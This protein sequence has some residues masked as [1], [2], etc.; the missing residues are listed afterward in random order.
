MP[1]FKELK[2]KSNTEIFSLYMTNLKNPTLNI[3]LR[4]LKKNFHRLIT[5]ICS[6]IFFMWFQMRIH[7][8][9][10]FSCVII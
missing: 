3:H 2:I 10:Q 9:I 4:T 7:P 6:V 1:N 8:N 5:E